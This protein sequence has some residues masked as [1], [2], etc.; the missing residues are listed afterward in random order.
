MNHVQPEFLPSE[1]LTKRRLGSGVFSITWPLK[2]SETENPINLA[3]EV[4]FVLALK[5]FFLRHRAPS[6][7]RLVESPHRR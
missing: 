1:F 5:V 2:V 3:S 7:L 6:V 4:S